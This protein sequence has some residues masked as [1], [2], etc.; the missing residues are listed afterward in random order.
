MAWSTLDHFIV[1]ARALDNVKRLLFYPSCSASALFYETSNVITWASNNRKVS[2]IVLAIFPLTPN[3][4][5][6]HGS[7]Y[8]PLDYF[9][10]IAAFAADICRDY[11][12]L[13][14]IHVL[15]DIKRVIYQYEIYMHIFIA[16]SLPLF[17]HT[18]FIYYIL[19]NFER[20][21]SICRTWLFTF[22]SAG[23][24]FLMQSQW[25]FRICFKTRFV[26]SFYSVVA[27]T[28]TAARI[29]L[30]KYTY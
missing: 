20:C 10:T 9:F 29:S 27:E 23:A 21:F 28:I 17:F 4:L 25:Q 14:Y 26:W 22:A 18:D 8:H 30:V 3:Y 1:T 13:A 15:S 5:Y 16:I 7:I 19:I 11:A 6:L 2:L 24:I 12:Q